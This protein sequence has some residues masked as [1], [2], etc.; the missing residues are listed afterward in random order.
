[1]F[2]QWIEV[3]LFKGTRSE[4]LSILIENR[5]QALDAGKISFKVAVPRDIQYYK[6]R[7]Y[8]YAGTHFP[9]TAGDRGANKSLMISLT[10][11]RRVNTRGHG[12][13]S[14]SH[15]EGRWRQA[16]LGN[17]GADQYE[18][19]LDWHLLLPVAD[20]QDSQMYWG[21]LVVLLHHVS[22]SVV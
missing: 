11:L 5:R 8:R 13:W 22:T 17:S 16:I 21:A 4:L 6:D 20:E 14:I 9:N 12:I 3:V 19:F 1:M 10:S 18:V 2:L 15:G 7:K